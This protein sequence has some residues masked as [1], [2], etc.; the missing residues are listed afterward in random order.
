MT[1]QVEKHYEW[2]SHLVFVVRAGYQAL[3]LIVRRVVGG[4]GQ[5]K[6]VPN[7]RDDGVALPK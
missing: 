4:C 3:D 6:N 5:S 7:H 2:H 1:G